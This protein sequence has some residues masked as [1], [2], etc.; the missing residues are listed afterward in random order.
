MKRLFLSLMLSFSAAAFAADFQGLG[1]GS[2][3]NDISADGTVVVGSGRWTQ[4][5]GCKTSATPP[6][7]RTLLCL[8]SFILSVFAAV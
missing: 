7:C 1:L 5:T 4:A 8:T 3:A 2:I 6:Q